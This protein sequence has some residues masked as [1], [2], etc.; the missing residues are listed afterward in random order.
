MLS[1]AD[2]FRTLNEMQSEGIIG[3]YAIGGGMA[4]LFYAEVTATYDIDVFAFIPSQSGSL[5]RLSE[6]YEWRM[7]R[8]DGAGV[9]GGALYS[10]WWVPSSREDGAALRSR[11]GRPGQAPPDPRATRSC[12]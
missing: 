2:V 5:I 12:F 9:S 10:G 11:R 7:E 6:I 4:A 1:L 3:D 8:G